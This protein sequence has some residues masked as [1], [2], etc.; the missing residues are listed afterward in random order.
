MLPAHDR[1]A[2]ARFERWTVDVVVAVTDPDTLPAARAI[3]DGAMRAVGLA[4]SRFDERSELRRIEARADGRPQPVSP[5]LRRLLAAALD[6]AQR[7]GGLVDPTVGA[8]MAAADAGIGAV[9]GTDA[10]GRVV[11]EPLA[12]APRTDWTSLRLDDAGLAL[13]AGAALDLGASAKALTADLAAER[14]TTRMG[15]GALVSLGGD[16][17]TRGTSPADGWLVRVEDRPGEPAAEVALHGDGG[18]ATSS[19]LHR[20]WRH[21][22]RW[23]P[24]VLDPASGRPADSPLRTVTVVAGDCLTAN[25]WTTAALAAGDAG[26]ALL[27]DLALSSRAVDRDGRVRRRGGWPAADRVST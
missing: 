19:S 27:D 3:V 15:C 25:A 1:P 7:T 22:E 5:L 14:I 2:S 18:L 4:C 11:L 23:W 26:D 12:E 8:A 20:G 16:L 10:A 9:V 24:H 13:P 21:G 17:A 6:V